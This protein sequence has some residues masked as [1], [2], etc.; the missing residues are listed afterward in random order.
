MARPQSSL[1]DH[2]PISLKVKDSRQQEEEDKKERPFRFEKMW[3]N[4]EGFSEIIFTV[5][6]KMG[7]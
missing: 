6:D 3:C 1:S 2:L 4:D 7:G 5:W